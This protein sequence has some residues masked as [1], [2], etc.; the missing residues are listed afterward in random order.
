M[1]HY[2][3]LQNLC[4]ISSFVERILPVQ[5]FGGFNLTVDIKRKMSNC[6]PISFKFENGDTLIKVKINLWGHS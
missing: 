5:S 2:H 1:K 4:F 3:Q 6:F